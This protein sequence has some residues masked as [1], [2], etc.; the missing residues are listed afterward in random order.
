MTL[1]QRNAQILKALAEQTKQNTVSKEAARAA[2]IKGGVYTAK[3]NLK[4]EFGG[5]NWKAKA[6]G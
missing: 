1:E 5:R 4:A 2:L 3:G 6:A